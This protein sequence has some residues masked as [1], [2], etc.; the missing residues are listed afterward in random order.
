MYL[1]CSSVCAVV[2]INQILYVLL[3]YH[4]VFLVIDL[5]SSSC[6]SSRGLERHSTKKCWAFLDGQNFKLD[7]YF[8]TNIINK[9]TYIRL[10][11]TRW[12]WG[13]VCRRNWW[14][15]YMKRGGEWRKRGGG[16]PL[17]LLRMIR[18][19]RIQLRTEREGKREEKNYS[20]E[21]S[22]VRL[23]GRLK[24]FFRENFPWQGPP[25]PFLAFITLIP[26]L[27]NGTCH[28]DE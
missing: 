21:E 18:N 5:R 9:P 7:Y 17:R 27:Q 3:F 23:F 22:L 10:G 1:N 15:K 12:W 16:F 28:W 24:P 2:N 11:D 14:R 4:Y 19:K 25:H 13:W 26:F 6:S 8:S 20:G